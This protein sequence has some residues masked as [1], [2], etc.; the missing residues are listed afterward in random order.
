[1][2][3]D[4]WVIWVDQSKMQADWAPNVLW[5]VWAK[6]LKGGK[7]RLLSTNG[8]QADPY[9]P[10]ITAADGY[11]AWATA[12]ADRSARLGV[13]KVSDDR[14]RTLLRH[15]EL[16]PDGESISDGKLVYLG[17]SSLPHHGRTVG[18]DCWAVNLRGGSPEALTH[19]GLASDCRA[20]GGTLVCFRHIDA[21]HD[22]VPPGDGLVDDPWEAWTKPLGDS[23]SAGTLLH[24]GYFSARSP[25]VSKNLIAFEASTDTATW[26]VLKDGKPVDVRIPEN[27]LDVAVSGDT[28]VYSDQGE[29][30]RG[31]V[32]LRFLTP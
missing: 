6:P 18:G 17:P 24:H 9:V 4:D 5:R 7:P 8:S 21:K 2:T 10:W 15:A 22:K 23:G 13:W 20:A 32:K 12:E 30:A 26:T 27:A 14:P 25:L 19:T 29:D 28:L 3:T 16:S 31:R 1:M 11:V